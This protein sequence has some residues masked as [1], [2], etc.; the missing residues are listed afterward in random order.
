MVFFKNAV[1]YISN[2]SAQQSE[3][4][5]SLAEEMGSYCNTE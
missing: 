3:K 1:G 5:T 2:E 4:S